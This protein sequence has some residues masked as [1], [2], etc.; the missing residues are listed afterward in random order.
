[1]SNNNN[2]NKKKK[3]NSARNHDH[4]CTLFMEEEDGGDDDD[5]DNIYDAMYKLTLQDL[6]EK[7]HHAIVEMEKVQDRNCTHGGPPP[8]G[9][10]TLQKIVPRIT[11]CMQLREKVQ[12]QVLLNHAHDNT[13]LKQL[14][15]ERTDAEYHA[16]VQF[17]YQYRNE[18]HDSYT[19]LCFSV[20]IDATLDGNLEIA[21]NYLQVG[22]Y[23]ANLVAAKK[24]NTNISQDIVSNALRKTRTDRCMIIFLH[25]QTKQ[26]CNCI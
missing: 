9:N 16:L 4:H 10:D 8:K 15:S 25:N 22:I 3:K 18:V 20:A 21:R 24:K 14:T 13:R 2:N 17:W 12:K 7:F 19:K 1:M 5:D 23:L 6:P 11:S 26:T